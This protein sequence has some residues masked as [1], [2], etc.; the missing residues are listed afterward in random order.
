MPEQY[1]LAQ[2]KTEGE[3]Y[4]PWDIAYTQEDIEAMVQVNASMLVSPVIKWTVIEE[5]TDVP[6][7]LWKEKV[8]RCLMK[9]KK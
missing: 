4:N 8:T 6:Y 2:V 9:S 3:P 7:D 5:A 1:N